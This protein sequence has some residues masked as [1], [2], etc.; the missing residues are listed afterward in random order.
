MKITMFSKICVLLVAVAAHPSAKRASIFFGEIGDS[1]CA[2]NVHSLTRS[3]QEMLKSK[4]MGGTSLS[5]ATY[6][7]KYLGGDLVLTS[8]NHVYRLD[9]QDQ[10]HKFV[11]EK[12]RITGTLDKK[13]NTIHI[14]TIEAQ[15]SD[16]IEAQGS[17]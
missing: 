5:C 4:S 3:H 11:A 15:R 8:K 16:K 13:S 1:Q 17:N 14:E 7:V 12:V 2:M 10:A 9:N 6:C